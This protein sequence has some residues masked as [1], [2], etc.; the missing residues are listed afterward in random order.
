M[1][2]NQRISVF[3]GRD[4]TPEVYEDTLEIGRRLAD[5]GYLVFCGGGAGVMEAIAKGVHDEGGIVVGVLKGQDLEEGN[6]YLTVPIATGIGIARNA[7]LAYNCDAAIAI[8]GQ[9]G[10]LSEIA[11]AFQLKKPVIGYKTWDI[12]SVVC[13]DSPSDVVIK[14]K[15]ELKNV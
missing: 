7:I 10:T 11:Y 5:E 4:I 3:G 9:Y 13:A 2:S 1:Y 8:S 14:L 6:K 15:K 12:D